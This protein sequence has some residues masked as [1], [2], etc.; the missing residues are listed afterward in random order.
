MSDSE[1]CR[2]FFFSNIKESTNIQQSVG[3]KSIL[4]NPIYHGRARAAG[5]MVCPGVARFYS[6]FFFFFFFFFF[7]LLFSRLPRL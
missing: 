5:V 1:F 4:S 6:V 3:E 2:P 7:F